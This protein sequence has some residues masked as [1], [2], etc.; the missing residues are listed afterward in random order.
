MACSTRSSTSSRPRQGRPPRHS[1]PARGGT[2]SSWVRSGARRELDRLSELLGED[3]A[4]RVDDVATLR[5]I[6][7]LGHLVSLLFPKP[8]CGRL[9]RGMAATA[10]RRGT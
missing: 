9:R 4:G 5:C 10:W 6:A 1:R 3:T 7:S 8:W 2:H